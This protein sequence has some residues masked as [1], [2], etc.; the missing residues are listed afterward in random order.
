[1]STPKVVRKREQSETFAV[2]F[3]LDA[4]TGQIR[5]TYDIALVEHTIARNG[6]WEA[7]EVSATRCGTTLDAIRAELL[8][9]ETPASTSG[10]SYTEC[11]LLAEAEKAAM[12]EALSRISGHPLR[13]DVDRDWCA[14]LIRSAD[15]FT[16][17]RVLDFYVEIRGKTTPA[18]DAPLTTSE[19]EE[20]AK[21]QRFAG[22]MMACANAGTDGGYIQDTAVELGLMVP[23][24]CDESCEYCCGEP[25]EDTCY[26]P[27]YAEDGTP[28]G[29]VG[30]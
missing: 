25:G 4:H 29:E 8:A 10:V 6:G 14:A 13:A 7:T 5:G 20:L 3:W 26:R 11:A 1:M 2:A 27:R 21:L 24:I 30:G 22:T 12:S 23:T 19:R 17:N 16:M 18:P 9:L 28:V 15:I